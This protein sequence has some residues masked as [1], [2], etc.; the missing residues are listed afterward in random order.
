M[1]CYEKVKQG[2][3]QTDTIFQELFHFVGRQGFETVD[4]PT[5]LKENPENLNVY[6]ERRRL[7][8]PVG[9][10]RSPE[11]PVRHS[12][13]APSDCRFASFDGFPI[14]CT[15][16]SGISRATRWALSQAA[17]RNRPVTL[18]P[19]LSFGFDIQSGSKPSLLRGPELIDVGGDAQ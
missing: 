19:P 14:N 1:D 3:K 8:C 7:R 15:L 10:L 4:L 9:T 6:F 12:A 16:G 13:A 11:V 17:A 2:L 5:I 18:I